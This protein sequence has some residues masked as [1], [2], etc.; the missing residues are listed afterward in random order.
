MSSISVLQR[1]RKRGAS[2]CEAREKDECYSRNQ[3]AE[4]VGFE[5]TIPVKVC[6]LSRRIVSTTHAPL[7]KSCQLS[8]ASSQQNRGGTNSLRTNGRRLTTHFK[9]P[10]QQ[11]RAAARQDAA[12]QPQPKVQFLV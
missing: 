6:P 11:L 5:P 12:L 9:G 2:E 4:R 7:R 8:A 10:L 3:L 1:A